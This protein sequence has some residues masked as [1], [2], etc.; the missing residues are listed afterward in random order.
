MSDSEPSEPGSEPEAG[1]D[2]VIE[3]GDIQFFFQPSVQPAD[4][5]EFKLGVQSLFAILSPAA[6]DD[7]HR[8][9]RIGRKRMPVTS[10]DRFWCR[11]ERV[12]SLQRVLGGKLEADRYTTKTRGE[13]YQPAARPVA[14]GTYEMIRHNDHTHFAYAIEPFAFEDAPDELALESSSHVVLF[15]RSSSPSP[16]LDKRRAKWT[17]QGEVS[18][19]DHEGAELVLVGACKG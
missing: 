3:R 17:A 9:M 5:D 4:A 10:K 11:I 6:G 19:L 7:R 14:M 18:L 16:N 12:G 2:P 13:R 15:E 1:V 8:R